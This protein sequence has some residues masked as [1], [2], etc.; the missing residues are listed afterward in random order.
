MEFLKGIGAIM[1]GVFGIW[2]AYKYPVEGLDPDLFTFRQYLFGAV[3]IIIGL[4]ILF[5]AI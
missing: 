4:I 5:K 3:C 2:Y 1:L